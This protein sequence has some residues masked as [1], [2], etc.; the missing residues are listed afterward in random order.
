MS[1]QPEDLKDFDAKD[2]A[3]QATKVARD[4]RNAP[5]RAMQLAVEAAKKAKR[6]KGSLRKV[7]SD[8][9]T[10]VR[11]VRA[12]GASEYRDVPWKTI[13]IALGAIIYFVNPF[14][15]IPDFIPGVGYLDDAL[16]VG[17]TVKSIKTALDAFKIWETKQKQD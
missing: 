14:D 16:V 1:E 12:W 10:L 3:D 13:A 8:L 7:V 6:N 9:A 17:V 11:L 15:A 4:Y 2:Q 5:E